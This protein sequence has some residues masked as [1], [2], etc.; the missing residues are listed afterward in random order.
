MNSDDLAGI[1]AFCFD[2]APRPWSGDE[3]ESVLASPNTR[4]FFKDSAFA[5]LRIAGSEAELLTIAVHPD[6]RRKGLARSLIKQMHAFAVKAGVDEVFLEVSEQNL[7]ARKLYTTCGY[8][9]R[10]ERKGYYHALN[11]RKITAVVMAHQISIPKD[12]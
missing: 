9:V 1:H 8:A 10:G 4:L 11:G 2:Y 6:F 5:I 3:I 7:A 12:E